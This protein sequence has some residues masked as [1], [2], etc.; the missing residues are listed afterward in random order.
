MSLLLGKIC[1]S[2]VQFSRKNGIKDG[3]L[4]IKKEDLIK[5]V[6]FEDPRLNSVRI[7]IA[8]PGEKT[9]II[10]VKD[11]IEPRINLTAKNSYFPGVLTPPKKVDRGRTNALKGISVVTCG[12][13]IGAQ[14]GILDMSGPGAEYS[15]FSKL[16][17]IVVTA[18]VVKDLEKHQHEEVLRLLGLRTAAFISEIAKKTEPDE[19]EIFEKINPAEK[20]YCELPRI[21][22]IYPLLSQ[23]LLHDTYVY[24]VNSQTMDPVFIQP[25]EIMNGAVVSGNCVSACDKNVTYH[26]Q[27]NAVIRELYKAHRKKI[28]FSAVILTPLKTSQGEKD[29]CAQ[30]TADLIALIRPDGVILS[31]EGFGNPDA[32]FMSIVS[33]V[34]EMGVKT[35]GIVDEFAGSDGASQSLADSHPSADAII[36]VG[37]AN[38]LIILPPM[39]KTIGDASLLTNLAGGYPKSLKPDGSIEIELQAI[40]GATNQLGSER[41]SAKEE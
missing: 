35:V 33:K 24:G 23:G 7:E 21:V 30:K 40:I 5:R 25:I 28:N 37:N 14:E 2:D 22:Y 16:I 12:Q 26:H 32:D 8:R 31:K 4:F 19:L 20:H 29:L 27:N 34:E 15:L 9:R 10:P 3:I 36:S 18:D 39:E 41:L 17:N 11:I 6:S 38:E 1:I 13:I